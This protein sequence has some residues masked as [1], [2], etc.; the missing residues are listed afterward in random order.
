MMYVYG[1]IPKCFAAH[2]LQSSFYFFKKLYYP[3]GYKNFIF[4]TVLVSALI[5]S[6]FLITAS[7][8]RTNQLMYTD[9]NVLG[10]TNAKSRSSYL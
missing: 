10:K 7:N 8:K 9:K 5:F 6:N 1:N 3:H 2:F 4:A